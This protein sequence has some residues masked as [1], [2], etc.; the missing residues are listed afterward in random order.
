MFRV[1]PCGELLHN[2]LASPADTA[3]LTTCTVVLTTKTVPWTYFT[4]MCLEW[5]IIWYRHTYMLTI[6]EHNVSVLVVYSHIPIWESKC[7]NALVSAYPTYGKLPIQT[8]PSMCIWISHFWLHVYY[9]MNPNIWLSASSFA[10]GIWFIFEITTLQYA[11]GG[12]GN[13]TTK[14]SPCSF[15]LFGQS[16][17]KTNKIQIAQIYLFF[18]V[19]PRSIYHV[20]LRDISEPTTDTGRLVSTQLISIGL[21]WESRSL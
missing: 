12:N 3:V 15:R 21:L 7:S 10:L 13:L 20:I 6:L 8:D 16:P 4:T 18:R 14:R 19:I 17:L 1:L 11:T 5:S 9:T 2:W